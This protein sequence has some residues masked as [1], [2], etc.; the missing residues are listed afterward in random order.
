MIRLVLKIIQ[1]F[2]AII[3]FWVAAGFAVSCSFCAVSSIPAL[4]SR[5][6]H[7]AFTPPL[8]AAAVLLAICFA[9]VGRN[10]EFRLNSRLQSKK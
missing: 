7:A 5:A 10:L 2:L 4:E 3:I 6:S 8:M 9:T 1:I